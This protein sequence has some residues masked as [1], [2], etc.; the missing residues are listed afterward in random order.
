[1]E[2]GERAK[3]GHKACFCV[4]LAWSERPGI[5]ESGSRLCCRGVGVREL[6]GGKCKALLKFTEGEEDLLMPATMELYGA[7][8]GHSVTYATDNLLLSCTQ[9]QEPA[10]DDA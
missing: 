8:E 6:A 5:D 7:N 1:M 3:Q 10:A 2:L 9:P 4:G